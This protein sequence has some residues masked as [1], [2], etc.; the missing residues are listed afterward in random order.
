MNTHDD[1]TR[2]DDQSQLDLLSIFH[3][4]VGGLTA[5]FSCM[6]LM[7]IGM[8]VA[9][10]SGAFDGKNPPPPFF[11]WI[12]ILIPGVMLVIGWALAT[13]IIL[14]GRRLKRRTGRLFCLVVAGLECFL[15][16]FGTV[17]GVFTIL[18]LMR[19]SVKRLFGE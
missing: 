16:P 9:M 8:G 2:S 5:L 4:V 17:L 3:Y 13:A 15:M 12:F 18:V 14:A 6:F 10:L 11:A 1:P 19:D 7:H